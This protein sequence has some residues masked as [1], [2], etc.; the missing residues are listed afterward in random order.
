MRL[1]FDAGLFLAGRERLAA[2]TAAHERR[3]D[4][5]LAGLDGADRAAVAGAL[6]ALFQLAE[7]LGEPA[8]EAAE[9]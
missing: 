8:D 9:R 1:E 4:A 3:M 7:Q 5:A 6:P 2:W